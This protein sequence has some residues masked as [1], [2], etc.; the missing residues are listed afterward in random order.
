MLPHGSAAGHPRFKLELRHM[1]RRA[2]VAVAQSCARRRDMIMSEF[3][4]ALRRVVTGEDD[5]GQ[6]I[7]ILD[8]PPSCSTGP[9]ELGGLFDIWHDEID[10][11]LD[12]QA[13]EDLGPKRPVLSPG[14]GHVKVRWFMIHPT[15]A[16]IPA[17]ELAARAR[18]RFAGFDAEDHLTDQT[19]HPAMHLTS[20]L[21]VIC[22]LQGDV[23]L[24]LDT[25][26]TRLKP[27]QVVI[28]RGT[29]H[30]WRA[31]GGPALLLAVLIDRRLAGADDHD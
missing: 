8:G 14:P 2:K 3:A 20:S 9:L 10:A 11:E 24:V 18:E 13:T 12:P 6:S 26:E 1:N 17:A 25:S 30:A 28:Q 4:A 27:G 21:D 23:S 5:Q 31:H 15:P 16:D 22:L 29:S 19:R 7:V